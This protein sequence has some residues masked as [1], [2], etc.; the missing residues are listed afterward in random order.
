M[1][2]ARFVAPSRPTRSWKNP[3]T[4]SRP[5]NVLRLAGINEALPAKYVPI[6]STSFALYAAA[7]PCTMFEICSASG[8]PNSSLGAAPPHP[9]RLSAMPSATE[10]ISPLRMM[11]LP[12]TRA[13]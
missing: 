4:A 13:L 8:R 3:F 10:T 9:I 12:P 6:F 5:F 7:N 1:S 2:T 11:T